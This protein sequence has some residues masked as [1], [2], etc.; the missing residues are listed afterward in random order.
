ME[1]EMGKETGQKEKAKALQGLRVVECATV[2]A[3]PLIG[4]ILADF[5]AEVIHVEHPKA[6]D[7]LRKFGFSVNGINPWWKYYARN[8]KCISLDISKEKGRKLLFELLKDADIFI[9]NFRPGRLEEW[10]IHYEDL[11][12]I[13]PRLIMVRVTG[14]GQHGAYSSQPGF[15]T[16]IEAMSGFAAM[17]GDPDGPPTLP[18]FPLADSFAA[19]YGLFAAMFAIYHRDVVGTGKGQVIDVSIWEPLFAMVGP[20]AVIFDLTGEALKRVGNRAFTSA[21]RNCYQTKDN[22]WLAIAGATQ[23]TAARLFDTMGQPDLIKDP[24]FTTNENRIKNV[25]ALDEIVGGWMK[26][27]TLKEL[28]EILT[29]NEVPVG[30][31]LD[32]T[33]IVKDPH[34]QEREMV[35]KAFDDERGSLMM[36]GIFPKMSLT[37]GAVHH[38]GRKMGA[39]NKEIFEEKLGLSPKEMEELSKE[40]II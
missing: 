24:R 32:I 11:A 5:G 6:G 14:F 25:E 12:K 10:N 39:D 33:D 4:R 18:P 38:A 16:L 30:P 1:A 7:H 27:Y 31:V 9:E 26:K 28:I 22:R 8:K 20:N 40:K 29:K 2:V 35:I 19:L 36:E 17:V 13:N 23:T 15:G 21:P 34:A 37:P 3:A